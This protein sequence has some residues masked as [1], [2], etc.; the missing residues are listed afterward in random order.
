MS[1]LAERIKNGVKFFQTYRDRYDSS[2]FKK[3]WP[4]FLDLVSEYV[5]GA[6]E[7][8]EKVGEMKDLVKEAKKIFGVKNESKN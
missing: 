2:V 6:E 1:S 7:F 8:F 3:Y 5:E 4:E